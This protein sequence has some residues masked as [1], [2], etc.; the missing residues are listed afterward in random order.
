MHFLFLLLR[1]AFH[2]PQR[3]KPVRRWLF[4]VASIVP[5]A[6]VSH[7]I[8]CEARVRLKVCRVTNDDLLSKRFF[9]NGKHHSS[10]FFC[11]LKALL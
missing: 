3:N 5:A 2:F 11:L 7:E 6:G 9:C 1:R 4:P 8:D 10:M